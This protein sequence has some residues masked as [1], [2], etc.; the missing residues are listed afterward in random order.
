MLGVIT[1]SGIIIYTFGE[2]I[3][4]PK[5]TEHLGSI[6]PEK[7]KS[8]YLSYLNISL[9]FGLGF[10]SLL[11][12]FFYGRYGEKATLAMGYLNK[13]FDIQSDINLSQSI[14]ILCK[15]SGLNHAQVTDLLWREYDPYLVWMP[16]IIIGLISVTGM[17]IYSRK[18]K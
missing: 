18:F 10:G 6:A 4:N 12:G 7:S 14:E 15:E 8:M 3:T 17:V 13:N 2:M 11:G 1:I 9:A 5:F 16:F